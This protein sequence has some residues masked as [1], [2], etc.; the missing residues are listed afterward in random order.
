[1]IFYVYVILYKAKKNR[2][3][4]VKASQ[5]LYLSKDKLWF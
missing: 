4:S 3:L 5:L 1:M 2:P